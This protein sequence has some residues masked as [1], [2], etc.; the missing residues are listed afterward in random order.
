MKNEDCTD[1]TSHTLRR[2]RGRPPLHPSIA[3]AQNLREELGRKRAWKRKSAH[4]SRADLREQHLRRNRVAASKYRQKHRTWSKI[5]TE[6]CRDET[7]KRKVLQDMTSS[8]REEILS[9]KEQAIQQSGCNC[10]IMKLYLK[11]QTVNL[12]GLPNGSPM[13]LLA[14]PSQDSISPASSSFTSFFDD[15][16]FSDFI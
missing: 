9:L 6:R 13:S 3:T 8:L 5:L 14:S 16:F 12:L 10:M 11:H 1:R 7:E 15:N 4:Y 2:R